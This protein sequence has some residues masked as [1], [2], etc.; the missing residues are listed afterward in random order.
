MGIWSFYK[1]LLHRNRIWIGR[2]GFLAIVSFLFGVL[3]F[4]LRPELLST[5]QRFLD[6]IF[7]D[8]LGREHL[9]LDFRSVLLIFK[10]NFF[11][12]ILIMF[13]GVIFGLPP[14][15][16]IALNFFIF[17][18]LF[19][20]LFA[21]QGFSGVLVFF[22]A[23]VPHGLLEIPALLIAAS[24]GLKLGVFY[25]PE[26]YSGNGQTIFEKLK[27]ALK[28]NF[29][30]LPLLSLLFFAAAVVEIFVTGNLIEFLIKR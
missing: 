9:S 13:L 29:Q 6:E 10:N 26:K 14:L 15:L 19:A 5:F 11:A 23:V 2:I 17:G 4:I 7:R 8:I 18:F 16:G 20:A 28:Q 30:V 24:F 12:S 22:T 3:T 1:N 25:L 21:S 27:V